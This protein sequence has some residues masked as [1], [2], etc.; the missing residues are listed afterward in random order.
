MRPSDSEVASPIESH[1]ARACPALSG[2]IW[3]QRLARFHPDFDLLLCPVTPVPPFRA[4]R[5]IYGPE[6]EAYKRIWTPSALPI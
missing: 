5:G 4:G 3:A 6:G 1:A 2:M